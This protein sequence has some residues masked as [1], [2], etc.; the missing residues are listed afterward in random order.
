[1]GA[2]IAEDFTFENLSRGTGRPPI[3]EVIRCQGRTEGKWWVMTGGSFPDRFA[4]RTAEAMAGNGF[5]V[6]LS[7]SPVPTPR[8]PSRVKS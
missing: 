4:R 3:N 7:D 6:V 5:A 8:F 2:V 1:M